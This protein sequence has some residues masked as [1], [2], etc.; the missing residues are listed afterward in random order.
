MI[1][2]ATC[3]FIEEVK[4]FRRF[5]V[6]V[7]TGVWNDEIFNNDKVQDIPHQYP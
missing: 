3:H 5:L 2:F 1:S 7:I 6:M 4:E